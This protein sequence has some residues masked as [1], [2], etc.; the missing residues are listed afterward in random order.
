L[1]N[2]IRKKRFVGPILA[3]LVLTGLVVS[4]IA[5]GQ[6]RQFDDP[7]VQQPKI[8]LP[9][10]YSDSL[11]SDLDSIIA[12]AATRKACMTVLE[13]KYSDSS[14]QDNPKFII[15]CASEQYGTQ[16]LVYWQSDVRE[17]FAG[18]SY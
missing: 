8:W 14:A 4:S 13:A 2:L 12:H 3:G 1:L 10:K 17:D 5:Q 11:S 7:G 18:V 15:T 6:N 16:N 9:R